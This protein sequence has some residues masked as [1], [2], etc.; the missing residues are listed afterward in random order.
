MPVP[1]MPAA[2][3]LAVLRR[4]VLGLDAPRPARSAGGASRCF[5]LGLSFALAAGGCGAPEKDEAPVG[6]ENGLDYDEDG[7]CDR[8]V[9]DW[10]EGATLVPGEDRADIFG[11]G[12]EGVAEVRARGLRHALIWPV[13]TT[14]LM[15]PIRPFEA[16][17]ND[18]SKASLV[19]LL[20]TAAGFRDMA[21]LYARLGLAPLPDDPA[22]LGGPPPEGMAPGDPMGAAI[23]QTEDGDGLVFSCAACHVS[24]LFGRPVIGLS[25]RQARPNAFFHIAQPLVAAVPPEEFAELTGADA[26]ETA[27]YGR[28]AAA[29]GAVGTKE[30]ESLGLDTSLA[31]VGLS[32]ARRQPDENATLDDFLA[33]HPAPNVLDSLVADSKPAVWWT[34]KYKTRWLSDGSIVSGNP[35]FTNFLWNEIGRGAELSALQG[36]LD[37]QQIVSD[38]LTVAVF[39]T[40]APRWTDWFGVEGIDEAEA[41]AGEA[42]F[43]DQCADCH[44]VYEK[45]WSSE[46][47]A[48]LDPAARLATTRVLYHPTTPRRD[49]G[50]SPSRA[51]GMEGL[52]EGLN[53]LSVSQWMG[54]RVE[55]GEGYVPPPLDG[56]WARYPY[57][58]NGSVPTLCALLSPAAA[59][60]GSFVQGPSRDP[61]TDYDA[62]CVG[63]P[64]GEA[65]PASWFEIEDGLYDTTGAGRSN[66]GHETFTGSE[67]ERSQLIAFLKTL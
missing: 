33:Q 49:V 26:G 13:G 23:V 6:C 20:E 4:A 55:V 24:E 27:M 42:I 5:G 59:R 50:T 54:A 15:L 22:L 61:A 10:S 67:E 36:W 45:A 29:L 21:G 41:M 53:R 3:R 65:I 58:H 2:L 51:Q 34:T 64:V 35:I 7:V 40:E 17:L 14:R 66:A 39:A 37:A 48:A 11:L 47:A 30:P 9:A 18:P 62:D 12:P 25:N 32:L 16:L 46:G 60:P 63:Y 56:V 44:G 57:L 43:L 8:L 28:F 19:D 1:P 52:A 31:Q 38:E